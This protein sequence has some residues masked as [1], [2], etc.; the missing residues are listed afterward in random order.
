MKDRNGNPIELQGDFLIVRVP[1]YNV[2]KCA[3]HSNGKITNMSVSCYESARQ[4]NSYTRSQD[5]GAEF[6]WDTVDGVSTVVIDLKEIRS[7]AFAAARNKSQKAQQGP[8][9]VSFSGT[10]EFERE[11]S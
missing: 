6:G 5:P 2:A 4:E 3:K 10:R 1:V 8:V 9:R 7:L 11:N